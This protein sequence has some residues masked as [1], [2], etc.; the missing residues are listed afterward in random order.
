MWRRR[1]RRAGLSNGI[2]PDRLILVDRS[3][4]LMVESMD[5]SPTDASMSGEHVVPAHLRHVLEH[6][7]NS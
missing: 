4:L 7:L 5:R 6:H 3:V 2:R 1:C